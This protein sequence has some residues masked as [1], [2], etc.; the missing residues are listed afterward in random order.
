MARRDMDAQKLSELKMDL[1][2]SNRARAQLEQL[3]SQVGSEV[4][5]LS[6]R[7]DQQFQEVNSLKSNVSM[8]SKMVEDAQKM[9]QMSRNAEGKIS[10]N[11]AMM[12]EGRIAQLNQQVGDIESRLAVNGSE[13]STYRG[14]VAIQQ[15]QQEISEAR[16]GRD[17]QAKQLELILKETLT[18]NNVE[19]QKLLMQISGVTQQLKMDIDAKIQQL[20][21]EISEARRGR[22]AQAKQLELILKET[23]TTNNVER[24]KLLMQ[25]SGVTQQLKMD[26]DAKR[27]EITVNVAI[28]TIITVNVAI[29]TTITVNVA[30]IT[31]IPLTVVV[32]T[33]ITMN[34]ITTTIVVGGVRRH[35]LIV[36]NFCRQPSGDGGGVSVSL[37]SYRHRGY[38][39]NR[40][41]ESDL[42]FRTSDIP[43]LTTLNS[44]GE[45][46][47]REKK[48]RQDTFLRLDP[49]EQKL[50][51][52]EKRVSE[53]ET[54]VEKGLQEQLKGAQ[55]G[56]DELLTQLQRKIEEEHQLNQQKFHELTEN[57]T[58]L[59]DAL[60]ETKQELERDIADESQ[61]RQKMEQVLEAKVEDLNDRL[62][63]ALANLQVA[64]GDVE[65]KAGSGKGKG[66]STQVIQTGLSPEEVAKLQK[67]SVEGV[68]ESTA[69]QLGEMNEKI[70]ELDLKVEQQQEMMNAKLKDRPKAGS[71]DEALDRVQQKVDSLAFSQERLKMQVQDLQDNSGKEE[72]ESTGKLRIRVDELENQLSTKVDSEKRERE[73]DVNDLRKKIS[74]ITGEGGE[75]GPG[76]DALRQD[77]ETTKGG[78]RKVAEAIQVVKTT[79]GDKIKDEKQIRE[80][81][82]GTLK[83]DVEK[84]AER[85][86]ELRD[87]MRKA[88]IPKADTTAA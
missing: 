45:F 62:R 57:Q 50:G 74:R 84:L 79:L 21:Q 75:D 86:K 33:I 85:T 28:I 67:Q 12:L 11:L 41:V 34:V 26:I 40:I 39:T 20:Q 53:S 44:G 24:Q 3:I 47:C 17:A 49:L 70:Q 52:M 78:L 23:L 7:F 19:R 35:L 87:R 68:R 30:I 64:I 83:R 38:N 59:E 88:G 81:E 46:E 9:S 25:I 31:I 43:R 80:Q 76:L 71:D 4:R 60:L 56:T 27:W 66:G 77:V 61:E 54:K 16:R 2:N 72:G 32:I 36:T 6:G 5:G 51:M 82:T 1:E 22:D 18:T 10:S 13:I 15:L 48:L 58:T 65:Q 29:I 55:N 14:P 8:Q 73:D 42:L 63:L 69:R 37:N